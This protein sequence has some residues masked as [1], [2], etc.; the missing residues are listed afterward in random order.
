MES[1]SRNDRAGAV[2]A[3]AA[4]DLNDELTIIL[5]SLTDSLASLAPDHPARALLIEARGAAQRCAWKA[6]GLLNFSAR[7][8]AR[9]SAASLEALL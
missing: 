4:H 3:A 8:G 6:S 5:T 7:R 1:F 9:P 2:A